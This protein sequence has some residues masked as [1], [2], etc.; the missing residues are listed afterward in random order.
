MWGY[1]GAG[2]AL[3]WGLLAVGAANLIWHLVVGGGIALLL[4]GRRAGSARFGGPAGDPINVL[5]IRLARGEITAERFEGL[6]DA[7]RARSSAPASPL[8]PAH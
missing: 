4:R 2:Q 5:A 7:I 3:G 6:A 1:L 8:G